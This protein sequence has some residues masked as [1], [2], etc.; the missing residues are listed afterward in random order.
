MKKKNIGL[1]PKLIMAIIIGIVIGTYMPRELVQILVTASSL[2]ST[3]LK[4]VIP[5]IILG[6]VTAGIADLSSGAGKLLGATTIISYVSTVIAGLLAFTLIKTLFPFFMDPS[7]TSKIGDPEA[8]MLPAIFSIPLK[9]MIDVTAAIVFAFMMGLGISALRKN[10]KGEVLYKIA[11]DFQSII[12]MVLAKAI[13]PLLPLY[14]AGTF[15]NIAF[16]G[17]VMNILSVFWKVYIVVM[18]LHLIYVALQFTVAGMYAKKNPI[19]MMKNQIPAYLTAV[20]TQ[21]SA[22]AIPVNVDCAEKNGISK[23]IREFVIPL[24]ATIHLSGSIISIVSFSVA[25]LMM[26]GMDSGINIVLPYI[27]MLGIAMVAAPG[28]PGGAVMSALPFFPMVGIP[29]DGGLASL[30][31]ALHI[32]QDSFGTAANISGDNAIAVA[33]DALNNKWSKKENKRKSEKIA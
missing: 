13:I 2:F 4:F 12:Q 10:N 33:V 3:F 15:A 28:A 20:G 31:I 9:P 22:A 24:C 7:L 32:T 19:E 29:A 6:F 8:G 1:I 16:A 23:Q 30:I 11:F 25:V 21:S 5:F 26:N 18:S 27:M 17:Q 14:I